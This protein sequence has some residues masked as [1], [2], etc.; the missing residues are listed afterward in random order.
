MQV[1]IAWSAQQKGITAALV[2]AKN[3]RQA[4]AN[5]NAA[6]VQ[7]TVSELQEIETYLS[8]ELREVIY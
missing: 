2:G 8:S 6:E 7:L 5:A 4:I 3:A 1:A